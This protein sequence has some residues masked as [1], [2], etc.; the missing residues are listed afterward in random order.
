MSTQ[1]Y[2]TCRVLSW[3]G[4]R[5]N[6]YMMMN[7]PHWLCEVQSHLWVD[8]IDLPKLDCLR[9]DSRNNYT[10]K[11]LRHVVFDSE[12]HCP[13]LKTRHA[14]SHSCAPGR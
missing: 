4:T 6:S 5:V 12:F 10:F 8:R 7:Q 14:Q 1:I 2:L 9:G 11:F 13:V 3:V